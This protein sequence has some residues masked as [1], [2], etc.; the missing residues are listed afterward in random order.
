MVLHIMAAI[1]LCGVC[2]DFYVFIFPNGHYDQQQG[3][4]RMWCAN[5]KSGFVC[6]VL[7][8]QSGWTRRVAQGTG[9]ARVQTSAGWRALQELRSLEDAV[10]AWV[11]RGWD[12]RSSGAL[13]RQGG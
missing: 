11:S 9:V 2:L 6:Q 3:V 4:P 12:T 5:D 13:F 8:L 10:L 7:S 1:L